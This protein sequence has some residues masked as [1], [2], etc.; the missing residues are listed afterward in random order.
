MYD[1]EKHK[2]KQALYKATKVFEAMRKAFMAPDA[3]DDIDDEEEILAGIRAFKNKKKSM[4]K[5]QKEFEL[6][7]NDLLAPPQITEIEDEE[8][9]KKTYGDNI[10]LAQTMDDEDEEEEN[11]ESGLSYSDKVPTE[12]GITI[13]ASEFLIER[14]SKYKI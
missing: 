8:D 3:I 9:K 11:D 10:Q 7:K 13:N 14:L 4:E 12:I 1:E 5:A 6:M 2:K